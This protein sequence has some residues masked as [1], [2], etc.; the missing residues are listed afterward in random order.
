MTSLATAASQPIE[1]NSLGL[2]P[3]VFEIGAFK[4]RWYSLAYLAGIL[5]GWWYLLKLLARPGAPMARRHA[6]DMVFYGTLGVIL[7]GRIGYVLFY[8]PDFYFANPGE[9]LQ[10]WD[11]GMSFHGG[12][13]GTSVA[14]F[15]LAWRNKLSVLRVHDY[16]V[17]VVPIGLFF[18]RLA[19]FVNHELW[20]RPTDVP[21]AV[22]FPDGGPVGRH[23]SQL[24]EAGLEGILLFTILNLLFWKTE[25]RYQPGKL[26]GTFLLGYG[27]SR[28]FVEYFRQPDQ[29]LENLSWGLTMGQTLTVPMI[30]IG[31]FL[32]AT[33]KSRRERV[34]PFAGTESVA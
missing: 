12:A 29:G 18:G 17:C 34:E 23:P 10:I 9:I 13:I 4:L 14:M 31:L 24:Y 21:W 1:W 32:I 6:D 8:R 20:G 33:A 2:D 25:A 11:G 28:F 16:I 27:L 19:N 30:L 7:G 3:I 26:V 5:I 22:V 15:Y